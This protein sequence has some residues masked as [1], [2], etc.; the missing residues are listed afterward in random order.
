[1]KG[2]LSKITAA[3]L[4]AAMIA[5]ICT[6]SAS[7]AKT[8][9]TAKAAKLSRGGMSSNSLDLKEAERVS[10]LETTNQLAPIKASEIRI[11]MW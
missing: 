9:K 8:A 3:V 11:S 7:A 2:D 6:V 5:C 4:S 10:K 1:M